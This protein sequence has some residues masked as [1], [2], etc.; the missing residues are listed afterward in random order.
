MINRITNNE[1]KEISGGA[2]HW[3][4]I[5]GIAVGIFAFFSGVVDGYL[6]PFPCRK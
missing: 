3:A 6:R 1:L 2:I 4:A 5:A